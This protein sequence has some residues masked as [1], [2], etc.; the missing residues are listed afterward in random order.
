MLKQQSAIVTGSASG[1]GLGIAR[2]VAEEGADVML[3]GISDAHEIEFTRA[4]LQRRYR[5]KARYSG[6]HTSQ[7][8]QIRAMAELAGAGSGKVDIV[9]NN[10]GIQ[11]VA[12][13]EA[14][15]EPNRDAIVAINMSSAF[16]LIEAVMPEMKAWR[17]G[18]IINIASAH[19]L[20]ALPFEAAYV[21]TRHG[22]IGPSRT[23]A[24]RGRRVRHYLQH[25][26]PWLCEDPADGEADRRSGEGAQHLARRRGGARRDARASGAQGVREGR[27]VTGA[28][29]IPGIRCRSVHDGQRDPRGWR[30]DAVLKPQ[31][32]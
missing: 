17:S 28:R 24:R 29:G 19:G 6:A 31:G 9:L 15:P 16:H 11:H 14:F 23:V 30:L 18:R 20:T 22:L 12:P 3:N 7:P 10:A 13:I 5:V 4:G 1:I 26:L 25:H 2:T 8:E 27:G 21:T 32:E